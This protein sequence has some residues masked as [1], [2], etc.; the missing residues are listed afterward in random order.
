[1]TKTNP[2]AIELR[3][4]PHPYRAAMA[5][6]SD[7]DECTT[8]T[9]LDVHRYLNR[10]LGLPVADSFFAHGLEPGQMA[11][12]KTDGRT[13]GPD[14]PLILQ[15]I[16]DR[17][18]DSIHTWG[19]FNDHPPDPPRLTALAREMAGE[20]GANE[21]K[22]RIWIN[23]GNRN[24]RQNFR[25]RLNTGFRG[26]DPT[27]PYYTAALARL[28]GVKFFWH[29]ELV[30]MPLSG[31]LKYHSPQA[32]PRLLENML[33]NRVKA[34]IGRRDRVRPTVEMIELCHRIIM[35]DGRAMIAF[36]RFNVH[37]KG[38]WGLPTRHTIHLNLTTRLLAELIHQGG[39]LVLYTHLGIPVDR[40]GPLFPG[41][42]AKALE[43]LSRLYHQGLIWVAPTI[44]LLVHRMTVKGLLW[45]VKAE[46]DRQIIQLES[47]DDPVAGPRPPEENELPGLCFYTLRPEKTDIRL[48]TTTLPAQRFPADH[49]GR[50]S[51]GFPPLAPP[52]LT[53]LE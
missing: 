33:K 22:V 5:I 19:D 42:D 39:Y 15:A 17:M 28:M 3:P 16:R 30:H 35:G 9:F 13:P 26:D 38:V 51:L 25:A 18:I 4:F 50:P 31:R 32:W 43:G 1:M 34:A 27:S 29:S 7:I 45:S 23:H 53:V 10:D 2:H 20:L 37:P 36:N 8:P 24:N 49:T 46:G 41:R 11:Y 52:A 12:F 6:C 21:L 44:D 48:G 47:I 40:S 14:A